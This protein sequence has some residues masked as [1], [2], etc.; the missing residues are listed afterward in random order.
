MSADLAGACAL[1]LLRLALLAKLAVDLQDPALAHRA[2]REAMA[3]AGLLH[4]LDFP[5]YVD[6][7]DDDEDLPELDELLVAAY[8]PAEPHDDEQDQ[9]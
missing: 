7:A 4:A 1:E 5:S 2:A 6:E 8:P 3:Q 9:P